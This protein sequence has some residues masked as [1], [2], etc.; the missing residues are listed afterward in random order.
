MQRE[1]S[2]ALEAHER[3]GELV[4]RVAEMV[5]DGGG[6]GSEVVGRRQ[7]TRQSDLLLLTRPLWQQTDG[8]VTQTVQDLLWVGSW[9]QRRRGIEKR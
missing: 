6:D 8:H 9:R 2:Q 3:G 5:E 1:T 7:T 4:F